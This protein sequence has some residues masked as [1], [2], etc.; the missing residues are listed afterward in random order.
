[1]SRTPALRVSALSVEIIGFFFQ[2]GSFVK[3]L[4]E[5]NR[6]LFSYTGILRMEEKESTHICVFKGVEFLIFM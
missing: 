4:T 2:W 5:L 1:M 3:V 6:T